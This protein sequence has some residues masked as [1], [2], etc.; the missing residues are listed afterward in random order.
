[1]SRGQSKRQSNLGRG[2]EFGCIQTAVPGP[3]RD[4][5]SAPAIHCSIQQAQIQEAHSASSL[6]PNCARYGTSP[7]AFLSQCI[8]GLQP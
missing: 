4:L 7:Q 2:M 6:L 1:M 8:L 3:P 5:G